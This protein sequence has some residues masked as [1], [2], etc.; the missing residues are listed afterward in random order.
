MDVVVL[1]NLCVTIRSLLIKF[2]CHNKEPAYSALN[3]RRPMSSIVARGNPY[4]HRTIYDRSDKGNASEG[5]LVPGI[6]S[7]VMCHLPVP[8]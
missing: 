6:V 1:E 8:E 7:R 4:H 2:V 3:V 5:S